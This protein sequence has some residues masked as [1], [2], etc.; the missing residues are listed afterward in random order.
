MTNE[1]G[2][3]KAKG[4][5]FKPGPGKTVRGLESA[6]RRGGGKNLEI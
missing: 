2:G 3:R 1:R 4:R 5:G 6:H